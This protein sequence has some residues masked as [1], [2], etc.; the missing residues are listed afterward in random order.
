MTAISQIMTANPQAAQ[1]GDSLRTVAQAMQQ[2][3]FGS[4]PVV[5]GGRLAGVVTDRDIAVRGVAQGLSSDE[6][7]S[8]VMTA[9]PVCVG[10]DCD[11][12]EAAQLM[13][14]KQIRRLYVT[15][16]DSL[17][18]VAALADVVAAAGDEL[19]GETI[20]KISQ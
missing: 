4:M 8:R 14:E 3:D 12:Q 5:D 6:P 18:G 15:E 11:L 7:V 16:N 10:P 17:V 9:E 2:G 20:E 1:A 13:Q 19:S